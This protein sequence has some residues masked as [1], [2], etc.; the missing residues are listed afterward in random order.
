MRVSRLFNATITS[1]QKAR[2]QHAS[3]NGGYNTEWRPGAK[4]DIE[5]GYR[6]VVSALLQ[7]SAYV[8]DVSSIK[9]GTFCAHYKRGHR[10]AAS[11]H[12]SI[13]V[14]AVQQFVAEE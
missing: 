14:P 2:R 7:A 12:E 11:V 10:H 1:C 8:Q 3:F 4:N 5:L 6:R 13:S 9:T